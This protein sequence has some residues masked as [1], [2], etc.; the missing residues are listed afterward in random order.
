MLLFFPQS[1]RYSLLILD[2]FHIG[3]L[4]LS[5]VRVVELVN[6]MVAL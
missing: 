6:D 3:F 4:L 2:K 5:L 1:L